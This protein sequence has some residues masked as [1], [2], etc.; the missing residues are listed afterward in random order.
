M[1]KSKTMA[2]SDLMDYILD[3]TGYIDKLISDNS[4]ESISRMENLQEM[5]GAAKEFE[6]R[7]PETGLEGFLNGISFGF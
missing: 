3:K 1:N 2:I 5:I 4:I 7:S 6:Q